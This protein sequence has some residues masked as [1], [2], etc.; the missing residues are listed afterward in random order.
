MYQFHPGKQ[1]LTW[2]WL[3]SLHF[4]NIRL[5]YNIT[6]YNDCLMYNYGWKQKSH[7]A[8]HSESLHNIIEKKRW[9]KI[10]INKKDKETKKLENDWSLKKM[11]FF[12]SGFFYLALPTCWTTLYSDSNSQFVW[13][14]GHPPR[15]CSPPG[16]TIPTKGT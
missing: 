12:V 11:D 3:H 2:W 8:D 6:K 15:F 4:C 14:I 5:Y 9:K 7:H 16:P 1:M 13:T 10:W